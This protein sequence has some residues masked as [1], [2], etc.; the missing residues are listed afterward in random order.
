MKNKNLFLFIILI[1]LSSIAGYM[2][3][4]R[5][6]NMVQETEDPFKEQRSFAYTDFDKINYIHLKR[7][8]YPLLVFR[9]NG[10]EWIINN[11]W[12]VNQETMI[13]FI[14]VLKN[15]DL[16]YIP[17]KTMNKTIDEDIKK[18]GIEIKLYT[19]TT[20]LEKHYFV[21]SEFG[22]GT[23]TPVVMAKGNQAFMMQ[24]KGLDGSI[25]RRM[26]FDLGEWRTKVI[27]R[28]NV[29]KIKKISI[30]YPQEPS[31]GFTILKYNETYKILDHQGKVIPVKKPNQK[32]IEAY[33]DF[34]TNI[35]GESNETENPER[36]TIEVQPKF[37]TIK[38]VSEDNLERKYNFYAA[39]DLIE[40]VKTTSPNQIDPDMRF[41][42]STY[43]KNF[44]LSQQRIVGKLFQSIWY[45]F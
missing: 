27:F 34:Y 40:E 18:N 16:K 21:G 37:A 14:A 20:S 1:L 36:K 19:D 9:R 44:V 4:N 6:K 15:M 38:L 22:D 12:P 3:Y 45:F 17:P 41:F 11:K 10:A 35:V 32:V 23:D 24:L 25:R 13:G 2:L 31:S 33:F 43:D 26:N 42:V 29:A 7:P 5:S 30:E 39:Q 8:R 28:E